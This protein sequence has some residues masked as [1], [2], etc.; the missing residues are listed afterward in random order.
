MTGGE[1]SIF[2]AAFAV[3]LFEAQSK[4]APPD[5][6][7]DAKKHTAWL[8]GQAVRAAVAATSAV[9]WA[10]RALD[11]LAK[12]G[13]AI[14]SDVRRDLEQMLGRTEREEVSDAEEEAF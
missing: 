11:E 10:H 1:Q 13:T 5:A 12:P 9:A 4:N 14:D 2:G 3:A 7:G 8:N 6:M